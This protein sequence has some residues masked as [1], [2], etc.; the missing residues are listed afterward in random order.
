MK[1]VIL[2]I[3]MHKTGTTSIQNSLV[4]V[5]Q[6][7][8]RTARFKEANHSVPMYTMF[9]EDRYNYHIWKNRGFTAD[10]I[11]D[12]KDDYFKILEEEL[13][14]ELSDSNASK[15]IISGEDLSILNETE[16]ESLCDFFTSKGFSVKIIYVVRDPVAWAISANQQRAKIGGKKLTKIN[17]EYRARLQGFINGCGVENVSVYKF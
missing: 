12:L 17:P 5:E 6:D 13:E 16:Q 14:K 8:I 1:Q 11:D 9:S 10:K 3:G 4:G 7:G 15:L 2:H